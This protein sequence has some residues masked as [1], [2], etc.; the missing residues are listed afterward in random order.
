MT[1]SDNQ[2]LQA[3]VLAIAEILYRNTDQAQLQ[4]FEQI[5]AT[6]RQHMLTQVSPRIGEFFCIQG[7][8]SQ[9]LATE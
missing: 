2:E 7:N 6:V 3:H 4:D 9:E 5:E 1:P 8:P